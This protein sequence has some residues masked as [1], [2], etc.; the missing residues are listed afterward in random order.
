MNPLGTVAK[1]ATH[2]EHA[3]ILEKL[4]EKIA[5][6]GFRFAYSCYNGVLV[7]VREELKELYCFR[8]KIVAGLVGK[9]D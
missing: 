1:M 9:C 4:V 3:V 6:A 5:L 7:F 2:R 8:M